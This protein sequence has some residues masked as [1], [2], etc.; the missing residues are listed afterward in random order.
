[1]IYFVTLSWCCGS[2]SCVLCEWYTVRNEPDGRNTSAY[3]RSLVASS[4]L[5]VNNDCSECFTFFAFN[6][7]NINNDCSECFTFFAFNKLNINNDC[8]EC[9]T[10]FAFNKLNI[11]NDCSEYFTFFAC[12]PRTWS[13]TH[14]VRAIACCEASSDWTGPFGRPCFMQRDRK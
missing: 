2:V 6:K 1:M 12:C 8:S 7:L 11:N 10:F 14:Y 5:N 13:P 9:F 3:S 4:K